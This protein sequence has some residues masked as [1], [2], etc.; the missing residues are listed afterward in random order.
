MNPLRSIW[1]YT[2]NPKKKWLSWI[3]HGV[4]AVF[5]SWLLW[6]PVGVVF[7]YFGMEVKEVQGEDAA[8]AVALARGELAE[9]I[10]WGDHI[11][12]TAVPMLAVAAYIVIWTYIL[13]RPPRWCVP[14]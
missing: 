6:M 12:D 4:G 13:K 8:R 14:F 2:T 7:F 10:D 9:P 11:M 5:F 3:S 1:V